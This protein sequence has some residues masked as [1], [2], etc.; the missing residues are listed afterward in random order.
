MAL[1]NNQA[2]LQKLV[3]EL[4]LYPA[5]DKVPSELADKILP[6]FQ[7][8]SEQIT[9]NAPYANVARAAVKTGVGSSTIY[10]TPATGKFYLSSVQVSTRTS[11]GVS[12]KEGTALISC[13]IDGVSRTMVYVHVV[14][15][16]DFGD[17]STATVSFNN[18]V[19][20]D[21]ATNI[22]VTAADSSQDSHGCITGYTTD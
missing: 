1:I 17:N 14:S 15:G 5:K 2:V 13:T 4:R 3:D 6:V 12:L 10:T 22:V 16:V 19:L 9:V 8:N 7:I 20:V 18:P 21:P 11:S